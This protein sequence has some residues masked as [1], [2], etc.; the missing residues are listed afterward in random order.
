VSF[1]YTHLKPAQLA[2]IAW[3]IDTPKLKNASKVPNVTG[4]YVVGGFDIIDPAQPKN[5]KL[6]GQYRFVHQYSY[7]QLPESHIFTLKGGKGYEVTNM[8]FGHS[9]GYPDERVLWKFRDW[10]TDFS[11]KTYKLSDEPVKVTLD[12]TGKLPYPEGEIVPWSKDPKLHKL[13][14]KP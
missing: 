12:W 7:D 9:Y 13:Y 11:E 14:R 10:I 4:G 5:E 8:R 3:S 2:G 1:T 6:I